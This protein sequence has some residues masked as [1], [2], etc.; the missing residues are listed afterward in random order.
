MRLHIPPGV[1][2]GGLL[3]RVRGRGLPL[4]RHP[5]ILNL[6][7]LKIGWEEAPGWM[8]TER[9][10]SEA[11]A[12]AEPLV[13][14]LS[15]HERQIQFAVRP[16]AGV[17]LRRLEIEVRDAAG[18]SILKTS[19]RTQSGEHL[20]TLNLDFTGEGGE[21]EASHWLLETVH[22]KPTFHW[23]L[24]HELYPGA[25]GI[26][27]AAYLHTNACGDFTLLSREDWFAL[28]GYPEFPIWPMHV[29]AL[30]CYSAYHAGL[31]EQVLVDPLRIYHIEHGTAAGWTPEGEEARLA[32][33]QS[34]GL[35]EL[36]FSE[37]AKWINLMRRFNAPLIFTL[38]G[39]GL[40][41]AGLPETRV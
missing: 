8:T 3:M 7:V 22:A 41:D 15:A 21:R 39:W 9:L 29:D 33:L 17:S 14:V 37:I 1:T 18:N 5:R 27:R 32:R 40:A 13:R 25:E 16:P 35:S 11:N 10:P 30:F 19:E 6:R 12:G 36:Q 20:V 31:R 2:S 23:P 26:P 24:S 34:K 28:R 38:D 4:L